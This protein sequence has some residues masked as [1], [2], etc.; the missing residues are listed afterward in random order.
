MQNLNK[1]LQDIG[2]TIIPDFVPL[3][4]EWQIEGLIERL[5]GNSHPKLTTPSRM[6]RF[7]QLKLTEGLI[8]DSK[9]HL[10]GYRNPRRSYGPMNDGIDVSK[11][12]IPKIL[13][14]FGE[15]LVRHGFQAVKPKLYVINIYNKGCR[16]AKH[17]DHDDN[18]PI[19]PVLG[20]KSDATMI[21][22]NPET[23]ERIE[24]NFPARAL[25]VLSGE[26]RYK[27]FHELKPVNDKRYSIVVRNI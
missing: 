7:G 22:T 19:I 5:P 2:V 18:G 17:I 27:W 23:S 9:A 11:T 12:Y 13:D 26:S 20:L 24:F 1:R 6:L 3:S 16:I 8:N 10:Q 15:L 25:V 21:L 14:S 4:Y